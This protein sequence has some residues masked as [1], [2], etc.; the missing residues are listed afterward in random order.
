V[1]V[2]A[3]VSVCLSVHTNICVCSCDFVLNLLQGLVRLCVCKCV[4]ESVL[5]MGS[6]QGIKNLTRGIARVLCDDKPRDLRAMR[7]ARCHIMVPCSVCASGTLAASRS[8]SVSC[9][10]PPSSSEIDL[11]DCDRNLL[12]A[13]PTDEACHMGDRSSYERSPDTSCH[14]CPRTMHHITL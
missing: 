10:K 8:S 5:S 11:C 7:R 9:Q 1:C 12:G 2:C 3:C 4:C 14:T 6:C 13:T